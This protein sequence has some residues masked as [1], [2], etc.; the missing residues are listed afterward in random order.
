LTLSDKTQ[1]N[2]T[3]GSDLNLRLEHFR[4][5][6]RYIETPFRGKTCFLGC[7]LIAGRDC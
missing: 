6:S 1:T 3:S 5:G 7:F 2:Q 4:L